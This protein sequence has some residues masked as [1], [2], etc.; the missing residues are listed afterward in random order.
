MN[1][2]A[3]SPLKAEAKLT[4]TERVLSNFDYKLDSLDKLCSDI[5][6]KVTSAVGF[7]VRPTDESLKEGPQQGNFV[8]ELDG[9]LSRLQKLIDKFDDIR[10]NLSRFV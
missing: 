7:E 9:R 6:T 4:E 10:F 3:G 8:Y 2:G 5:T 1:D